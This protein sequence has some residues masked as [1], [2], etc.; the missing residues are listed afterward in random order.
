MPT[1][2]RKI[3]RPNVKKVRNN[4]DDDRPS[5]FYS[6]KAWRKLREDYFK[7][8]PLCQNCLRN[9]IVRSG[10]EVHHKQIWGTAL[11]PEGKW[12]LFLN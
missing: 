11:T 1:I 3:I 4:D 7:A 5:K 8:N 10:A 2:N 9:G 12:N 6:S